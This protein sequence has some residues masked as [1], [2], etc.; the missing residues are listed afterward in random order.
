MG[1]KV[2]LKLFAKQLHSFKSVSP[3][4]KCTPEMLEQINRYALKELKVEDVYVRKFLMAHNCIDRDNE[5]FPSEMLDQFSAT[6]PGK[7]M[8]A[9]H[10]RRSTPFGTWFNAS[11]EEMSPEQ[12]KALTD[13]DPVLPDGADRCKV[14][15]TWSYMLNKSYNE[16]T[17][18]N[19]DAG[20]TRHCSIGF[21]AADLKAVRETPTGPTK[22]YEYVSP[23]EALEGSLVWLG[24]QPGATAQK[25]FDKN[26]ETEGGTDMKILIAGLGSL[27][28]KSLAVDT[29]EEA[30]LSEIKTA[31]SG[32]DAKIKELEPQAADGVAYRTDLIADTVKFAALI[33]EVADDEKAKKDEEEFLKSV[34]IGR[35][36]TQ[37]DKYETRAREKFPTHAIFIGKDQED[38][39]KKGK[40][41]ETKTETATGKKDFSRPEHNELFGTTGR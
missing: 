24:A 19:L 17:I 9:N 34:P 3:G 41:A 30:L 5:C 1:G 28:G 7:S 25:A 31:L 18:D 10:D 12:F 4:M 21:A 14:L 15:W 22:Y 36:K 16:Q 20:I 33:G 29:S 32:K 26:R 37:R 13:E 11:T 23:G 39:E 38:R 27:F 40:A 8:L 35:L 6:M 2:E